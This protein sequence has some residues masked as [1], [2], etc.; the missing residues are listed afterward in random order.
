MIW[1]CDW[2]GRELNETVINTTYGH[3]CC[4]RCANDAEKY[5]H[6]YWESEHDE[7]F[8]DEGWWDSGADDEY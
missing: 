4:Q 1:C 8:D 6:Q 5:E 3:F 7:Y 2:C